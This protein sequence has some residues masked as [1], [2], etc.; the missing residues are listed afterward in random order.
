MTQIWTTFINKISIERNRCISTSLH[1]F[2]IIGNWVAAKHKL[3]LS[4]TD[5]SFYDYYSFLSL[6][7][8]TLSQCTFRLI[9]DN[10][11]LLLLENVWTLSIG[12]LSSLILSSSAQCL[13]TIHFLSGLPAGSAV[14]EFWYLNTANRGGGHLYSTY[15]VS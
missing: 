9:C 2:Y 7:C 15:L 13:F 1:R 11:R 5:F 10:T 12:I 14:V 4:S 6:K 3:D 8:I